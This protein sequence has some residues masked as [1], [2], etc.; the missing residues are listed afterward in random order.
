[1][2]VAINKNVD[3]HEEHH[4]HKETFISKWIFGCVF[5][6]PGVLDSTK[7]LEPLHHLAFKANKEAIGRPLAY[8][9]QCH[10]LCMLKK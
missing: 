2:S 7:S 1:M 8:T 6:I 3:S 5:S 9:I 10:H 4:H